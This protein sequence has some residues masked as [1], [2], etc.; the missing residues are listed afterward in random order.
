M[1]VKLFNYLNIREHIELLDNNLNKLKVPFIQK[2]KNK[3]HD[4][5]N[6]MFSIIYRFVY[7][8]KGN[9][10]WEKYVSFVSIL[11]AISS[12]LYFN[13]LRT[14]EQIGY[15]VTSR[16][17]KFGNN[18]YSLFGIKFLVQSYKKDS[19]YIYNRTLN[20]VSNELKNFI[21]KLTEEEFDEYRDGEIAGLSDSFPNILDLNYYLYLHIF[22]NSFMYDYKKIV[23][24]QL[25]KFSL[26]EFKEMFHNHMIKNPKIYSISID[27]SLK[28]IE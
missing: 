23:I 20:F 18:N 13:I 4:E 27:T 26:D 8:E 11:E 28:N 2:Y 10:D 3:S 1:S 21:D 12:S 19:E 25:L 16:I 24:D 17:A 7:L 6:N 14:I 5:Q 15:I 22:D 9:T